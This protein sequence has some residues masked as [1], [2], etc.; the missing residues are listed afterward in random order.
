[1]GLDFSNSEPVAV[2]CP[3]PSTVEDHR[4]ERSQQEV[5]NKRYKYKKSRRHKV[6][7]NGADVKNSTYTSM[8]PNLEEVEE[9]LFVSFT[10]KV[11]GNLT[12]V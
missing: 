1:M 4:Q 7:K 5:A 8:Q 6:L 3:S 11:S 10:S 9:Q 12:P 2:P